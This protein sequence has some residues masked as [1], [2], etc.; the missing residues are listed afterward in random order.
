MGSG[1]AFKPLASRKKGDLMTAQPKSSYWLWQFYLA[2]RPLLFKLDPEVS[3]HLSFG[4]LD[5]LARW[6][7]WLLPESTPTHSNPKTVAGLRFPNMVGLAAGLD[8]NAE[9]IDALG[10]F[11]F[12]FI[13]VGTV[14]PK[15]QPGNPRPRLFRLPQAQAI[16]NR[17]GFNNLGLE[18][19]LN[20]VKA[21]RWVAERRGVLGLNIGKNATTP[22]ERAV[23][24]YVLC[25]REVYPW[26]DYI[27]VNISSPNT[28]NLR[29]LQSGDLLKLLLQDLKKE[30]I[31]CRRLHGKEVPLFVKVAPDLG[32]EDIE[33]IAKLIQHFDIEGV[34]AT[35]TTVDKSLVHGLQHA[36]E[37]GGLSGAPLS[38]SSSRV[39][40]KLRHLLGPDS[41]LIGVGGIMNA[42]DGLEKL[43]AGADL[44]QV[45][46]GLIYKGPRLIHDLTSGLEDF[47]SA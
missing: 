38:I 41:C 16:I 31:H 27:T 40:R 3:H 20:N 35:N 4:S 34:I 7:P 44:I 14:T 36:Q 10:C 46:S 22:V 33:A 11:G 39:L 19:F 42:E 5:R 18:T 47:Q 26:A 17:F 2:I 12:G 8:K 32:D 29:D 15:G 45:Y 13:E 1:D 6:A 43:K 21:S 28:Q 9:H 37:Q 23:D 25:M 30:Q 24:D